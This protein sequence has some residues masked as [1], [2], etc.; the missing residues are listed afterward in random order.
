MGPRH[1]DA[2]QLRS[3][4]SVEGLMREA[5]VAIDALGV[6]RDDLGPYLTGARKQ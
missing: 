6:P 3:L 4:Q 2:Q 1:H 5:G